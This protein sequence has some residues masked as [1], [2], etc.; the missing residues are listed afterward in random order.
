MAYAGLPEKG[1]ATMA[2]GLRTPDY[3]ALLPQMLVSVDQANRDNPHYRGWSRHSYNDM[4][5]KS[6]VADSPWPEREGH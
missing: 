3:A 6:E 2:I 4:L 5:S 1:L